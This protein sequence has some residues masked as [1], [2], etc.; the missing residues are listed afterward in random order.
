[1]RVERWRDPG[2]RAVKL[3]VI[4]PKR[5][6]KILQLHGTDVGARFGAVGLEVWRFAGDSNCLFHAPDLELHIGA[7]DIVSLNHKISPLE[8]LEASRRNFD[9]VRAGLKGH[10]VVFPHPVGSRVGRHTGTLVRGSDGCSRDHRPVLI[11]HIAD[12]G[13]VQHLCRNWLYTSQRDPES[14]CA[15]RQH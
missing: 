15:N 12:N 6:G 2:Q 14:N 10:E 4:A 1:M 9:G 13:P 7:R 5:N 8:S 3:L 11:H